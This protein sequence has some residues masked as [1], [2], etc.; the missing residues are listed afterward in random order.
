M[1]LTDLR[2]GNLSQELGR[3]VSAALLCR[4]REHTLMDA[5]S[6]RSYPCMIS[7]SGYFSLKPSM[8]SF[9]S[10]ASSESTLRSCPSGSGLGHDH[11]D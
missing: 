8:S 9:L 11:D 5:L 10:D 6:V 4:V 1:R 2:V 7:M 3:A